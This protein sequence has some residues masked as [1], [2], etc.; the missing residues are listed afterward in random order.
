MTFS[1]CKFSFG[2]CFG[3][4]SWSNH[5]A[6]HGQLSYKIYFP[7]HVTIWL[8][9]GSLLLCCISEDNTSKRRFFDVW[10]AH[11]APTY[12]AFS[13]FQFAS[14]AKWPQNGRHSSS[15]TS[16]VVVTD[17]LWWWLSTGCCQLLMACHC[18]PHLQGSRLWP[19]N[20][21]IDTWVK[22]LSLHLPVLHL[23]AS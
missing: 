1:W 23:S 19:L 12:R 13:P 17:Q 18:D 4:S 7:L 3:A 15:T 16:H 20:L 14:N 11:K 22:T 10:S 5:W 21:K 9:N 6:G 8:R 2:K